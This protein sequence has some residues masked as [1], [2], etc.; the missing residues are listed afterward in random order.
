[1]QAKSYIFKNS[2]LEETQK[3]HYVSSLC[4]ILSVKFMLIQY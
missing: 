1:M 4:N 2:K 3:V